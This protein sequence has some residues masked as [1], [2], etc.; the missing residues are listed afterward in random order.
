MPHRFTRWVIMLHRTPRAGER[1][2]ELIRAHVAH[3]KELDERGEL[4][5][6]GPLIGR[7]GGMV[8]VDVMTAGEATAIGNRDPFVISGD[9]TFEVWQW[10]LSCRENDHLGFG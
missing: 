9:S 10:L 3:L 5:L 6:A 1:S 8:V 2:E 4:V 7:K